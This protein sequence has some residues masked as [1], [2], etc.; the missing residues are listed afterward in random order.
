MGP[1][2]RRDSG[3]ARCGVSGDLIHSEE[4]PQERVSKDTRSIRG[5]CRKSDAPR[6]NHRIIAGTP[7]DREGTG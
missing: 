3:L 4:R 1:G 2:L 7:S 5:Q 6:Y